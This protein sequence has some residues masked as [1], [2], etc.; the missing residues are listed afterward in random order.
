MESSLIQAV[1]DEDVSAV[2]ELLQQGADPNVFEDGDKIRPLHFV[3]Q[4]DSSAALEI[5]Q[6][7]IH[8]GAD[9]LAQTEPDGQTPIEVAELMSSSEMVAILNG[10]SRETYH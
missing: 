6:L 2:T 9:P 8:A 5:A 3:A 7:L 1:L 4:K 10:R